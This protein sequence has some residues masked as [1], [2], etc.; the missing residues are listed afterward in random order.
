MLCLE[1]CVCQLVLALTNI[2]KKTYFFLELK[3]LLTATSYQE[4]YRSGA[5]RLYGDM[6]G[7]P[8][9][10]NGQRL[11]HYISGKSFVGTLETLNLQTPEEII[12]GGRAVSATPNQ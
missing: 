2:N 8:H 1:A 7:K 9:V 10:V 11:K 5:L 6:K 3:K 4:V 12:E